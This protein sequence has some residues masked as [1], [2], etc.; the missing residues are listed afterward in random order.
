MKYGGLST[1]APRIPLVCLALMVFVSQSVSAASIYQSLQS[2]F[3]DSNSGAICDPASEDVELICVCIEEGNDTDL[4]GNSN[5]QRAFNYFI[6]KGFSAEQAAGILGNLAQESG[7]MPMRVQGSGIILSKNIKVDGVTGYGIAQW[8][9]ITRQ[10]ALVKFAADTGRPVYSLALQLDFIMEEMSKNFPGLEGDLK[11]ITGNNAIGDSAF[12]FHKVFEA[13]ADSYSQIIE[14]VDS[15]KKIFA[16]Y[17][18][19]PTGETGTPDDLCSTVKEGATTELISGNKQILVQTILS[20]KNVV[21]GNY[22]DAAIQRED[23]R[24]CLTETTL[25][26]FATMAEKSSVKIL[27]NALGT[28]HGGCEGRSSGSSAHNFGR[29]IDIGYYGNGDPRHNNDGDTLYKFLYN[30]AGLL[31]IDQLIWTRPPAGYK[32]IAGGKPADCLAFYGSKT[33]AQHT[34]HIHVGFSQ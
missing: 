17:S 3:Y 34:H 25:V 7:I 8:T 15:G 24:S 14:R 33:V 20:S 4:S 16:R 28:D 27:I 32:C 13:S 10:Q 1:I 30:N 29:A 11:K 18:G 23:V 6:G 26:G 31:K 2:P 12:L 19:L 9:Y 21:F 22:Q 5:T